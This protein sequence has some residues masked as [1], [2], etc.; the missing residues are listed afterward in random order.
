MNPDISQKLM[1]VVF[2]SSGIFT[3]L[4]LLIIIGY[5]LINGLNVVDLK[6]ILSNPIDSGKNGGIFPIIISTFYL[7]SIS[8]SIAIPIGVGSAIY[9]S[10]YA[11]N[12]KSIIFINFISE[13]LVSV[14]SII[15]GLFGFAFLILFLKFDF[16]I[17]AGG[18]ILALMSIPTIFQISEVSLKAVPY[19]V[20][21]ASLAFGATK[22]QCITT[23]TLPMAISGIFTGII[24][25]ITRAISEAAAVMYVVGSSLAMPT[26]IF[27]AGRPLALHLFVL[28]SEG[29]SLENAY[30]TS[31]VLILIVLSITVIS[32]MSINFYQSKRGV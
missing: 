22:W 18:V 4:I 19:E 12:H 9:A 24:L 11:Q 8:L 31:A 5:I 25:A 30:G 6:F 26:S 27:D 7:I 16:S 10:E 3:I 21:E 2:V 29:V 15:F 20:K 1:N 23:V 17:L 13:V 28:A 14:P 32:N